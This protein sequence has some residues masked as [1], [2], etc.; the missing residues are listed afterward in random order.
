[1]TLTWSSSD[2]TSCIATAM[3]ASTTWAGTLPATSGMQSS[4]ALTANTT[5]SISCTGNDGTAGTASVSVKV[6]A[7]QS[8]KH[9]GGSFSGSDILAL[10]LALA[11]QMSRQ[12]REQWIRFLPKRR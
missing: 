9:G 5:F 3:P 8:G 4:G 1:M 10:M 2:T 7:V 12:Q 6:T 11:W